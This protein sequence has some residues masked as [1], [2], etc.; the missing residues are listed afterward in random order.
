MNKK[1]K[2]HLIKTVAP[3]SIG[4]EMGIEP[5]DYLVAI[6]NEEIDDVFDYQYLIK[7]E[8]VEIL[9]RKSDGEE[10][11]LEID[12]EYE[13]DLGID[14]ENSLMSD[15]RS[16]H[17]KCIFCFIDQ[18]PEGMRDT[19]YFKDDDS[20]LSFLQGNY[21]TLTNMS[22]K[23]INRIIRF[24]LSPINISVQ[25][26]NPELRNKMLHNRFA[27]RALQNL[28]KLYEGRIEMNGQIV[29]CKNVNDGPEL[30][31]SIKDLSKYLPF[32]RSV[33]VVPAGVTKYR[34]GLHPLEL[35]NKQESD[36]IIDLIEG[37][38]QK[39]YDEFGLHFIHASD[40]FYI[41]AEREFPEEERYDGYIQLENGVGM[42]RLFI[43]EFHD[44]LDDILQ[45]E[46]YK[47]L[48]QTACRNITIATGKLAYRTIC[49]FSEEIMRAFPKIK[50]HTAW[51]R[52][53][54]FGE[55]IT[56][57][58]LITGQDL[59][60]QLKE[61]KDQGTDLGDSLL[62]PSSMLR[63]GENVFLDDITAEMVEKELEI[64]LVPTE[65]GGY[66]FLRSILNTDYKM[67]RNNENFV[68]VKAY[69]EEKPM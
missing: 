36:A 7:D 40:E 58:G 35:Y 1:S 60:K 43:N 5:G 62:I 11:L 26:T 61:Q 16:C 19:L 24:N 14:F 56:V 54:F 21:I 4:E 55:T 67:N 57:A 66:D 30:E 25:T 64:K 8:Y 47:S 12:K 52:N 34:Q 13:E 46:E 22:E 37:C 50:I 65:S 6:N 69:E 59:I 53:D 28:D 49:S 15:Y 3:D 33:S 27:G 42:M 51:I 38:Q 10:W 9:I 39:F 44:A 41:T 68:Y 23:D 18:M 32:M 63:T 20:R 2:G 48:K 17:N 29:L 45:S 31:R